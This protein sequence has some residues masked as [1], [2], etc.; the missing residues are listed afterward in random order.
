MTKYVVNEHSSGIASDCYLGKCPKCKEIISTF[1][2]SRD[3]H[4]NFC[5]YC[6]QKVVW[7]CLEVK[8]D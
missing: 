5:K 7:K 3:K 4:T 6:G 8:K 1:G 2:L